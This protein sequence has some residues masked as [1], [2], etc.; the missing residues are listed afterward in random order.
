MHRR[1]S[2]GLTLGLALLF[3]F[4]GSLA[5]ADLAAFPNEPEGFEGLSWG[6][7]PAALLKARP[8]LPRVGYTLGKMQAQ[9]KRT[10]AG[11]F[12]VETAPYQGFDDAELRYHVSPKGLFRVVVSLTDSD[13][14][15]FERGDVVRKALEE[16]FGAPAKQADGKLLW[17]G[18]TTVIE[19]EE[20]PAIS[21]VQLTLSYSQ[22]TVYDREHGAQ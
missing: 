4:L 21:G 14:A 12:V 3:A 17:L 10:P 8:G 13:P 9:M 15:S 2:V 1:S 7:A 16:K 5:A 20:L 11:I 22:R 18:A 19:L 6:T